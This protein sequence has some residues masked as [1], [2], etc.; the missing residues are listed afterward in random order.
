ME[1]RGF[2]AILIVVILALLLV[3]A[4]VVGG[5]FKNEEHG[6]EAVNREPAG[7]ISQEMPE[8]RIVALGSSLSRAS[9]LSTEMQG[10]NSDYSFSTGTK[11]QSVYLFLKASEKDLVA[12]NLASPG[13]EMR[14][15]LE[16]QLPEALRLNPKYLTLDPGADVVS[17]NSVPEYREGLTQILDRI[18]PKTEV[19]IFT[20]PNFVEMRSANFPSC[21]ENKVGVE[22]ENLSEKNIQLF[23]TVIKEVVEG[24]EN[25]LLVDIYDLFGQG[26]ISDYDCLHVNLAAQRKLANEFIRRL[27]F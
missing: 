22:L 18:N 19:M 8:E 9:N 6:E 16:R 27:K 17:R 13:A 5:V 26:E 10:E 11:M 25:V 21:R 15:I 20:Y 1:R 24:R 23:N 4:L 2:S 12:S 14:D 3:I 7:A